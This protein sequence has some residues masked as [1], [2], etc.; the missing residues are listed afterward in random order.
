MEL[1]IRRISEKIQ[2]QLDIQ[3]DPFALNPQK[4][5]AGLPTV[6]GHGFSGQAAAA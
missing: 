3:Y 6:W 4:R 2:N 1:K 5:A